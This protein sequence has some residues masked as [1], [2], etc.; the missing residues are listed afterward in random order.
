MITH[1]W[2]S[3]L[4]VMLGVAVGIQIVSLFKTGELNIE[5][6]GSLMAVTFLIVLFNLG[7][8]LYKK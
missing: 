2:K 6:L 7:F 4:F 1:R 5:A 3:F 8:N